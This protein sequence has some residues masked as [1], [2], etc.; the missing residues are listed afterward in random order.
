MKD[1]Y[2]FNLILSTDSFE[3]KVKIY[4]DIRN[5]S[6]NFKTQN[7][8]VLKHMSDDNLLLYEYFNIY[9]YLE[10]TN[11]VFEEYSNFLVDKYIIKNLDG[12][13]LMFKDT[14]IIKN[15][16]DKLY[17]KILNGEIKISARVFHDICEYQYDEKLVE[18]CVNNCLSIDDLINLY[19]IIKD[20]KLIADKV[21]TSDDISITDLIILIKNISGFVKYFDS[22]YL[23]DMIK[24]N[25]NNYNVVNLVDAVKPYLNNETQEFLSTN[26]DIYL[27]KIIERDIEKFNIYITIDLNQKQRASI[28]DILKLF[29]KDLTK[30]EKCDVLD[31]ELL[32]IGG[33][34]FVYKVGNK[35][36]KYGD[37]RKTY[38]IPNSKY[39]LQP[40]IRR[41]FEELNDFTIEVEDFVDTSNIT[42]D[43]AKEVFFNLLDDGIVMT[44]IKEKNFGRLINDNKALIVG[45]NNTFES[46]PQ[47]NGFSK[48]VDTLSAGNIVVI[49]SDFLYSL[50]DQYVITDNTDETLFYRWINEYKEMKNNE[51]INNRRK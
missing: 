7:D 1:D 22:K 32:D 9:K 40:Y 15:V 10:F 46:I 34:S 4:S 3:D 24:K 50:K 23:E 27:D 6:H 25:I 36:L 48:R 47:L 8:Y 13:M 43:D 30:M 45:R 17:P 44:D 18:Y 35:V 21:S 26:S 14:K 2:L 41:Q 5:N 28:K 39:I 38:K 31:I 51:S 19:N 42:M 49:D 16:Y 12:F 11:Q 37:K 20:K 33:Y 29:F